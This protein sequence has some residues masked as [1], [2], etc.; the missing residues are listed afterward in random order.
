MTS[1]V[2]KNGRRTETLASHCMALL[3]HAQAIDDL[4]RDHRDD[5]VALHHARGDRHLCRRWCGP[6]LDDLVLELALDVDERVPCLAAL[7]D[8]LLREHRARCLS[9]RQV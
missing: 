1:T 6:E 5:L 8:R 3:R 7:G 4:V 9:H 2:A